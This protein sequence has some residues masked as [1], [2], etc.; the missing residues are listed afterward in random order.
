MSSLGEIVTEFLL[1]ATEVRPRLSEPAAQAAVICSTVAAVHPPDDARATGVPLTTGSIAEFYIEPMLPHIGDVDVMQYWSNVLAVPRGHSPPTKLPDEFYDYVKV[2][3]I[4]DSPLPGYVYL[5]LR[6]LLKENVDEDEFSYVEYDTGHYLSNRLYVD[7]TIVV[8]GPAAVFDHTNAS[9]LSVDAVHCI[10]CLV[11]PLQATD[12]PIRHR[13]NGWPDSKTIERI[14]GNGCDVVAVAHRQC[15]QDEWIGKRQW[16]LSFSRAE[17]VLINSW[18]PV[19]QIVYHMLR[20]FAKT[21]KLTDSAGDSESAVLSNYHIKTLM[22][23]AC[24]LKPRTWWTQNVN[25]VR[26]CVELL[27]TLASWMIDARCPHYFLNNCNLLSE[28]SSF[29]ASLVAREMLSIDEAYL[30]TWFVNNYI[31][32]QCAQFCPEHVSQMLRA[33]RTREQLQD[34]MSAIVD[35]RQNTSL[36]DEWQIINFAEFHIAADVS[37]FCLT[38]RSCACY[39]KELAKVDARLSVHFTAVALLQ[40]ARRISRNG[41]GDELIDMLATVLGQLIDSPRHYSRRNRSM[42]SLSNATKL[43]KVVAN[44]SPCMIQ[45]IEIQ[46]SKKYLYRSLRL[47]DSDSDCISCLANVYLAVLH[48]T[49]GQ[50]K[51]ALEH[52]VLV[53]GSQ[54]HSQCSSHV[55]QGELLPQSSDDVDSVLGLTVFY[56]YVRAAAFDQLHQSQHFAV[57]TTELFAHYVQAVCLSV[58]KC[59]QFSDQVRRYRKYVTDTRQLFVTDVLLFLSLIRRSEQKHHPESTRQ[60][61][62]RAT[63]PPVLVELLQQFAVERLKTYRQLQA[64]DFGSVATIVTTDFEALYAYKRGDF[65]QCLQLSTENLRTLSFDDNLPCLPTLPEFIQ[66]LDDDIVSLTALTVIVNE[67][68]RRSTRYISISQLTLSLYL[69][70]QCQLKLRHS[71]T[72]LTQTL[73]YVEVAL[74]RQPLRA[75]LNHLTLKLTQRI[76][77]AHIRERS[78]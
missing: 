77:L 44:N 13:N 5:V 34:A 69:I 63:G 28:Y 4:I 75:V 9:L 71:V 1:R 36:H 60:K 78:D 31:L 56:Q 61:S 12:W 70:T 55:V 27:H 66:L 32:A 68:C 45:L 47:K 21:S 25:L 53:T 76:L 6:Y 67:N 43:M 40:V 59:Q 18:M 37:R 30:A 38:V 33:V 17:I 57:F 3:E 50:Y 64:R 39:A 14:V 65:R 10:R 48:Y 24:E 42:W 15:R 22:L 20:V 72:S 54:D 41:F 26:I 51:T 46:L 74:R 49:T 19:Q 73:E 8:H 62:R 2:H 58:T 7:N 23:W 11:W 29:N 16:R 35:W 52:C